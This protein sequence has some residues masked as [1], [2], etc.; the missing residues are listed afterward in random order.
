M[1]SVGRGPCREKDEAVQGNQIFQV[2]GPT[3]DTK[4][5]LWSDERPWR[6][7]R[8]GEKVATVVLFMQ[9]QERHDYDGVGQH[10]M[11]TLRMAR[12]L[13]INASCSSKLISKN[14][15]KQYKD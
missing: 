8:V 10:S 13:I 15:I 11:R 9:R 5:S 7:R 3:A 14:S 12:F 4:G 2:G 1:L 6:E